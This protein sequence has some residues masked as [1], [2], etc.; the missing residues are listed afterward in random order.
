MRNR[1]RALTRSPFRTLIFATFMLWLT[2]AMAWGQS[3][4]PLKYNESELV[5]MAAEGEI[6][7]PVLHDPP[8]RVSPDGELGV[9]PGTGS[10]TYNFRAGDSAFRIAADHVEPAVSIYN[11]GSTKDRNS[12]ENVALNVLSCIGN[13]ARVL[14]G[15]AKGARGWVIGK[16]GGAEHIMVDFDDAVYDK[17]SI[18]DEI[19]IRTIGTGMKLLNLEGVHVMNMSPTLLKALTDAG[20]GVTSDGNLRIHVTHRVPAKIMG[21]GLGR[22]HVYKGDYDIN[23]FDGPTIKE[24][25]LDTIRF[26]DIVA[27]IDADNSYGR[28]YR[29]GAISIG[30]VAHSRS[31]TAGHGPGVVTL[32]AS[33]E[34]KIEPIIDE[35]ANLVNLL[36]IRQ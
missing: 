22:N 15:E 33:K 6:S 35:S 36:K 30:V 10:I 20:T 18:G 21:S 27:L 16:H 14:S 12:R 26:G 19:Q 11:L 5:Q 8:Y 29:T 31:F 4:R 24:Y 28:I 34:G 9:Y 13:E 23:L 25:K 2:T 1:H 32:F 3:V 7:P 17:L